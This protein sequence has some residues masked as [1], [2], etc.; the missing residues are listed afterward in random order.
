MLTRCL[1]RVLL[2]GSSGF[3]G[4]AVATALKSRGA[5]VI[6]PLHTDLDLRDPLA[7]A[8]LFGP[9]SFDTVLHFAS[10]GVHAN[11]QD[12]SLV[13][14]ER[15]MA[16]ALL[17][18]VKEGGFFFYAGS[19]SEYGCQG[20]LS[21]R[22]ECS[23]RNAYARAKLET[24]L[25]IRG[26][27]P[28]RGIRSCVGR[29]FGAYGPGEAGSRLFPIVLAALSE[30]RSVDLSDGHQVRDFVHVADIVD[31]TLRLSTTNEV[32]DCINIGSGVGLTVRT[33]VERVAREFGVDLALLRFGARARSPHDLDELVADTKLLKTTLG[34]APAQHLAKVG[35]LLGLLT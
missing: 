32:P 8:E 29:I 5:N 2:T 34:W 25:Y 35:S 22:D 31:A 12:D 6:A 21:E 14:E 18:T 24:G 9:A 28:S 17:P 26:A 19:V 20:R 27:A 16:A 4:G 13:A 15:L 33:V 30:R 1:G 11:S 10:R 23:P 3:I 7:V